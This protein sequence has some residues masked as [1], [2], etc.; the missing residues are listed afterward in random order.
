MIG[1]P[2]Q[3]PLILDAYYE[4]FHPG[5][6]LEFYGTK[7][8]AADTWNG[9]ATCYYNW[10]KRHGGSKNSANILFIDG[11]V[12]NSPDARNSYISGDIYWKWYHP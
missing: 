10:A 11:H 9:G 2:S 3:E 12:L 7:D 6:S 8:G 5:G 4:R 1:K